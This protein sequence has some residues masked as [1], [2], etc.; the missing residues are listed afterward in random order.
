VSS[1]P[2]NSRHGE[3]HALDT[4]DLLVVALDLARNP[5]ILLML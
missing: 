5:P 2:G 3:L 1:A 4:G